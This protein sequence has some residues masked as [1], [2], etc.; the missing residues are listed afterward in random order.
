MIIEVFVKKSP[1]GSK[2]TATYEA[3][4]ILLEGNILVVLDNS[5]K[6]IVRLNVKEVDAYIH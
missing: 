2:P 5:S 3:K 6:P 1:I 4:T